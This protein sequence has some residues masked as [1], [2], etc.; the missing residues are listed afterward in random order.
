MDAQLDMYAED[1]HHF[2]VASE[3]LTEPG[4]R[5][6]QPPALRADFS[7]ILASGSQPR[8]HY[9]TIDHYRD[10]A[11]APTS[12]DEMGVHCSNLQEALHT[13]KLMAQYPF[14]TQVMTR[15]GWHHDVVY[16]HI[17]ET[18]L[19]AVA[20]MLA[21]FIEV[22][23]STFRLRADPA[24]PEEVQ[25]IY[26]Q[27][28][29]IFGLSAG[30]VLDPFGGQNEFLSALYGALQGQRARLWPKAILAE[31]AMIEATIPFRLPVRVGQLRQRVIEANASLGIDGLS[32][33]EIEAVILGAVFMANHDVIGFRKPFEQFNRGSHQLLMEG[34]PTLQTPEGMFHACSRL[35]HFLARVG[36][37]EEGGIASVFHSY[38]GFPAQET[39][40]QW[41]RIA[42]INCEVQ[43]DRMRSYAATAI[44]VAAGAFHHGHAE[45]AVVPFAELFADATLEPPDHVFP[46]VMHD[47]RLMLEKSDIE[48]LLGE[49]TVSNFPRTPA[50]AEHLLASIRPALR[51]ALLARLTMPSVSSRNQQGAA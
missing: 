39:R 5:E 18:I 2:L 21:P 46:R 10:V 47:M 40:D 11:T 50:A 51:E 37:Q 3:S 20:E 45:G 35:A 15:A 27:A 29:T 49:D 30:Q 33:E 48:W 7:A 6:M 36:T 4:L 41:D 42:Q 9:H 22:A 13:H 34:A 31:M 38:R 14:I 43:R 32:D 12:L 16:A 19:P 28:L 24:L 26:Q 1:W 25:A 23:E 8:R 44:L 17:D